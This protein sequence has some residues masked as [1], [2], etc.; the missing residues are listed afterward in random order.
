[1]WIRWIRIQ[2]R[3]RNTAIKTTET[4]GTSTSVDLYII[5]KLPTNLKTDF[6]NAR[7]FDRWK[8]TVPVGTLHFYGTVP[9]HV[10]CK[11]LYLRYNNNTYGTA[12]SQI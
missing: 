2:I 4:Y 7:T 6:T 5:K 1:M 10:T 9:V 11:S 12:V 3:I 8:G